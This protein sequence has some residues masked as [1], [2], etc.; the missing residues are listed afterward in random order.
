M[1]ILVFLSTE[2]VPKHWN[3]SKAMKQ[4]EVIPSKDGGPYP[5]RILLGWCI[6][7]P[8]KE[9]TSSTT[10]SCNRISVKDMAYKTVASHY[11]ATETEVKYVRIKQMLHGMYAADFSDHCPPKKGKDITDISVEDRNFMTL[12]EKE[13]RQEE[14]H[15]KPPLSFR[16]HDE[17]S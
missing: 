17:S 12:M 8:V 15:Y 4:L 2:I 14:K 3:C 6:V 1:S 16:V 10:A 13:C 9:T 7:G 11:F 5:F